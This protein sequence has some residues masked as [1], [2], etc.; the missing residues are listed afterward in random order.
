MWLRMSW[1][2]CLIDLEIWNLSRDWLAKATPWR[3]CLGL[4][5]A[6]CRLMAGSFLFSDAIGCFTSGLTQNNCKSVRKSELFWAVSA[7][8]SYTPT[9]KYSSHTSIKLLRGGLTCLTRLLNKKCLLATWDKYLRQCPCH[10]RRERAD[11][12]LKAKLIS[13]IE[14]VRMGTCTFS[15]R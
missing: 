9:F 14:S 7:I 12:S 8:E 4:W 11:L 10:A 6:Y 1:P 5:S 3:L 13:S 15:S 2:S